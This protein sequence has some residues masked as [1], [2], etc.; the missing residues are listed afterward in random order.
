MTRDV[1]VTGTS[2][3]HFMVKNDLGNNVNTSDICLTTVQ[4]FEVSRIQ[5]N[6]YLNTNTARMHYMYQKWQ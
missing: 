4:T 3:L 1:K 6:K 5:I 2:V